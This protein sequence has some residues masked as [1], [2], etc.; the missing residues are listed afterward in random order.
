[1]SS[2]LCCFVD[3][4]YTLSSAP[5]Q[6]PSSLFQK[7]Y[8]VKR[9]VAIKQI[10]L[11]ASDGGGAVVDTNAVDVSEQELLERHPDVLRALL[12]D[13]SRTAHEVAKA[14]KEGRQPAKDQWNIIWGTNN[15]LGLGEV[16]FGEEDEITEEK[17]TG[18]NRLLVRPRA[19]KEKEIQRQRVRDMAEVFTPAWVCNAQNNLVDDAWFGRA[20]AF[21][22][23]YVDENG[24]HRWTATEG[25]IVFAE[26]PSQKSARSWK[27]YV[28]DVRL[29]I[30]CGE[31][32]YL[33]SR[34][35]SVT[36]MPETD[37]NHRIGLLDRKLRVVSENTN[38]SG[39]WLEW[40]QEAVKATYGY[41]WQGDSLLLAREAVLFTVVDYYR[42]KFHQELLDKSLKFF[43]YI[44]SWNLWQ[45]DGLK[46]VIPYSCHEETDAQMDFFAAP[47]SR[48]C[49]ACRD[50]LMT[51][52]NGIKCVIRDWT[53]R[54]DQQK[55]VF[56]NVFAK[57]QGFREV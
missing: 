41:E 13:H 47:E 37:L 54:R 57:K 10:R 18:A 32:P 34:Y 36:G 56:E 33:V 19:V 16:G 6:V 29:E 31:A 55:I 11:P 46:M 1:M 4:Y 14:K 51:E 43:A 48:G 42:G 3:N 21:N 50:G 28:R 39:E 24:V 45:M 7:V 30:T 8:F 44:I 38:S 15:Y 12:K 23:E 53:K 22:H 27:D 40:A 35:D 25:K 17:I 49:P 9:Q 5:I 52:H 26:E 20:D 2:E